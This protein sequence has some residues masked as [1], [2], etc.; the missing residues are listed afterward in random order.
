MA[1]IPHVDGQDVGDGLFKVGVGRCFR[2]TEVEDRM[3]VKTQVVAQKCD[4]DVA[5]HCCSVAPRQTEVEKEGEEKE[6]QKKTV[7]PKDNEPQ[8]VE[9]ER[10]TGKDR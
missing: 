1:L 9:D 4:E 10:R 5:C 2:R 3:I 8:T 6:T 7:T